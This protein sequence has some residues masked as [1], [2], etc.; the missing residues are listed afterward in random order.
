MKKYLVY[1]GLIFMLVVS[2]FTEEQKD[3][4]FADIY[5][6]GSLRLTPELILVETVMPK[7]TYFESVADMVFDQ[8]GN[9]YVLDY[10][11]VNIK[12][13][14]SSG[15][16]IELIG[17]K[18]QGPGEFN[19][20]LLLTIAG[21]R[22]F[23][24]DASTRKIMAFSLDGK[25]VKSIEIPRSRT[26]TH[27]VFPAPRKMRTL[28]NGDIVIQVEKRYYGEEVIPQDCSLE[29]YTNDLKHKKTIYSQAV[30]REKIMR[31]GGYI[32]I[33]MPFSP[34]V[35]WD[36]APDGKIIIGFS[37]EY[38]LGI[39]D[40]DQGKV[41]TFSHTHNPVKVT[42]QDKKAF[43][44][45]QKYIMSVGSGNQVADMPD[46]LK[47][48]VEFPDFKPA[49][50]KIL[51]DSKGNILVFSHSSEKK[52]LENTQ[53]CDVFDAEGKFLKRIQISADTL[54]TDK[55]K[56]ILKNNFL[57]TTLEDEDGLI[58]V[59]KYRLSE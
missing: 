47:K 24:W 35:Y 10:K 54:L 1:F 15:R 51:V 48:H 38:K 25:Y 45:A 2:V 59:V 57:W 43:F 26:E 6:S 46:R 11:A 30:W 27:M 56:T 29:I 31:I 49:F 22:L 17:R 21:E 18:G 40:I 7:D 42:N 4:S 13:F 8:E 41:T 39:Y 14:D 3:I 20:P 16:F 55:H 53:Y 50:F 28:P 52:S 34:L 9:L 33:P 23:V 58:K 12:K 36:V 37:N 32:D 19:T 44:N 5:A